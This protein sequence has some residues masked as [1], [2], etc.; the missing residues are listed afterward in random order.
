MNK[1]GGHPFAD[2]SSVEQVS[3]VFR[4]LGVLDRPADDF[5]REHVDDHIREEEDALDFSL[6]PGDVPRPDLVRPGG[7]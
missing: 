4:I 6:Q 7:D 5:A 2:D 1:S 3:G